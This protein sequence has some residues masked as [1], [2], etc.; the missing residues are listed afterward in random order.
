MIGLVGPCSVSSFYVIGDLKEGEE[1]AKSKAGFWDPWWSLAVGRCH[2]TRPTR[3]ILLAAGNW[4]VLELEGD[5][6]PWDLT[7][8]CWGRLRKLGDH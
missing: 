4:E 3:D 8:R 7:P 5:E 1:N 2:L 6:M